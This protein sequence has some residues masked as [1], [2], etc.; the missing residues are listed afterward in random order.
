M[1]PLPFDV[2]YNKG[3]VGIDHVYF[4]YKVATQVLK[5]FH[6]P[7]VFHTLELNIF[8][9]TKA[10]FSVLAELFN[11]SSSTLRCLHIK[12][13][14]SLLMCIHSFADHPSPL[15]LD[16]LMISRIR[17]NR[18]SFVKYPCL[19][20]FI[21]PFKPKKLI[22]VH[23][24]I[25]LDEN[26]HLPVIPVTV[27]QY[28]RITSHENE[29]TVKCLQDLRTSYFDPKKHYTIKLKYTRV[30]AVVGEHLQNILT[31]SKIQ[32]LTLVLKSATLFKAEFIKLLDFIQN[33]ERKIDVKI[34]IR[35]YDTSDHADGFPLIETITGNF[36]ELDLWNATLLDTF[37]THIVQLMVSNRNMKRGLFPAIP[38]ATFDTKLAGDYPL[39]EEVRICSFNDFISESLVAPSLKL[40]ESNRGAISKLPALQSLRFLYLK[41]FA[42]ITTDFTNIRFAVKLEHI[43][44]ETEDIHSSSVTTLATYLP[45]ANLHTFIFK[46]DVQV[47]FDDACSLYTALAQCRE[48]ITFV[49]IR[50]IYEAFEQENK[51]VGLLAQIATNNPYLEK[52]SIS[53][54]T[55][56]ERIQ[57]ALVRL[58]NLKVYNG[59]QYEPRSS[60]LRRTIDRNNNNAIIGARSMLSYC[61]DSLT[62]FPIILRHRPQSYIF[63]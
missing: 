17:I 42:R 55:Q 60:I 1:E 5:L 39:L 58:P 40:L 20:H 19:S 9:G 56:D 53:S 35:G 34:V 54:N 26:E 33:L 22:F 12:N 25:E 14:Q 32:H 41:N 36:P 28:I 2:Y 8:T 46:T 11:S 18:N 7:S 38:I 24:Q 31:I 4:D 13:P 37:G 10:C 47:Q 21:E 43:E 50:W 63:Q 23:M 57:Q 59:A 30:D 3:E 16:K 45:L 6:P 62:D 61:L 52:F 29:F 49:S 51:L 27:P 48:L 44:I 15:A